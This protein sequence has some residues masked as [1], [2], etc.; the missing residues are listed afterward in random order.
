MKESEE[1]QIT[2]LRAELLMERAAAQSLLLNAD[3][4]T[5]L[6]ASQAFMQ[7]SE[8]SIAKLIA[9]PHHDEAH[10]TAQQHQARWVLELSKAVASRGPA[11][12]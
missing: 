1:V 4:G 6:K 8:Q 9:E 3:L 12:T 7:A 2:R 10:L 5:L 11:S